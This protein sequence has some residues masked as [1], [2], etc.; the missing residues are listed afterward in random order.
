MKKKKKKKKKTISQ[1]LRPLKIAILILLSLFSFSKFTIKYLS[2]TFCHW[3][4]NRLTA[5]YCI[6]ITLIQAYIS[7]QN[8]AIICLSETFLKD[9][10]KLEIDGYNL[11]R[12]DHP[13]SSKRGGVCIYYK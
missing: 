12:S 9:D 7:H 5:H 11:I 10:H 3:D 8:F 4:L 2:L 1:N 6:K 13:T